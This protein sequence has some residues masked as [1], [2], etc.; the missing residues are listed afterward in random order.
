MACAKAFVVEL[1]KH[2]N[3]ILGPQITE[4]MRVAAESPSLDSLNAIIQQDAVYSILGMLADELH[5][6]G[7]FEAL[8][9]GRLAQEATLRGLPGNDGSYRIIRRRVAWLLGQLMRPLGQLEGASMEAAVYSSLAQLLHPSEDIVVR[10]MAF[11]SLS[12]CFDDMD[13][14]VDALLPFAGDGMEN[15]LQLLALIDDPTR[16]TSVFHH[17]SG[18]LAKLDTKARPFIP[19]LAEALP[20]HW[21]G[22]E[23]VAMDDLFM[24]R[25]H[26]LNISHILVKV[27]KN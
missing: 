10:F 13:A 27:R 1:F 21:A 11:Q 16:Q 8:F 23:E 25:S 18:I 6:D 17:L 5:E 24:I 15:G 3:Q 19:M 20:R 14:S 9:R 2:N 22:S 4:M 12:Q 7:R 26:L